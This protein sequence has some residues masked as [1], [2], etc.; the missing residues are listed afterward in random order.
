MSSVSPIDSDYYRH[1]GNLPLARRVSFFARKRVYEVFL[2]SM[3]PLPG[4][5]ILDIGTSD[6]T[7]WESNMLQQCYPHTKQIT[8]ASLSDGQRIQ[9]AY[10]E[11]KHVQIRA[12]EKLPFQDGE[13]DII[14][15]NA[16]LEHVG[17]RQ[18]QKEFLNEFCRVGR[19]RFLVVP[20]QLFPVEH[21]TGIPLIH[22]LPKHL[23]RKILLKTKFAIWGLEENLNYIGAKEVL[24]LWPGSQQPTVKFS[25][26]G[27]GP[28]QSNIT[29]SQ[30]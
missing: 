5:T 28:L 11:V 26:I 10:P 23:F 21:H 25:G 2:A 30:I 4:E 7:N 22:Y 19:K 15:S 29:F 3:K 6:E 1:A 14:H 12:G 9:A 27:I 20:N 8:C 13:F 16:V 17:S 24:N 18:R